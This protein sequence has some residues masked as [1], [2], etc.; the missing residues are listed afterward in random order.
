MHLRRSIT[1]PIR[2]Y[3]T[4][5]D[6]W[7]GPD[8]GLIWCWERG[9]EMR[10]QYPE[11][12]AAAVR[13]ELPVHSITAPWAPSEQTVV[14]W[15]GGVT[16]KLKTIDLKNGTLQ[17]LAEW[18]GLRGENLD[19]DIAGERVIVCSRT[20]QAVLFSGT[21]PPDD[22]GDQEAAESDGPSTEEV[23]ELP[24]PLL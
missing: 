20:G 13:G 6:R 19:I 7:R 11:L 12:A 1:A 3:T 16:T 14:G 21:L 5:G 9:R 23:A 4:W 22:V 18:Q 17:Y 10:E 2:P 8:E 15:R 24:L